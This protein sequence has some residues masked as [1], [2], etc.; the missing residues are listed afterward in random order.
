MPRNRNI[1][2]KRAIMTPDQKQPGEPVKKSFNDIYDQPLPDAYFTT[3]RPLQYRMPQFA[4]PMFARTGR[5]LAR[6]RG[7]E[8]VSMLDLCCGYGVN[9]ALAN[10]ALTLDRLY[11]HYRRRP[12]ADDEIPARIEADARFFADH[13]HERP[14]FRVTGVDVAA[15]ALDYATRTGIID[16]AVTINLEEDDI[17]DTVANAL[18]GA[19][20]ITVT[21]GLSYIGANSFQRLLSLYPRDRMPWIIAF[22]LR[23][24]DFSECE[25]V[26]ERFGLV[27]QPWTRTAFVQRR[28]ADDTERQRILDAIDP[29]ADPLAPEPS[30]EN[31]EAVVYLIR[32]EADVEVCSLAEL[33]KPQGTGEGRGADLHKPG[34]LF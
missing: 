7:R 14:R 23:H 20:L 32:P 18:S 1:M 13:R 4:Q 25:D 9:G 26:Y 19:D 3:L 2:T 15:N 30:K 24:T 33:I 21:G 27:A 17:T 6:L 10:Y 22:P 29:D 16:D 31:V 34:G 12:S 5:V 8:T 28:F 11:S